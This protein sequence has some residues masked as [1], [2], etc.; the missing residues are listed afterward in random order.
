MLG[1]IFE[2]ERRFHYQ[3]ARGGIQGIGEFEWPNGSLVL[4][5]LAL[6]I[7][8]ELPD[9]KFFQIL[10]C[11]LVY[12]LPDLHIAGLSLGPQSQRREQEILQRG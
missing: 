8:C 11:K 7:Q 12:L 4:S 1:S 10:N 9:W 2:D 5:R 3:R 6:F